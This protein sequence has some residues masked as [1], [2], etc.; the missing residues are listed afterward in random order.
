MTPVTIYAGLAGDRN[1]RGMRGARLLGDA[2]AVAAG[3]DARVVGAAAAPV[4]G[5]WAAQLAAARHG[6]GLLKS[7]VG[8]VLDA[9]GRPVS[10][11]GRCAASIATLPQV[12]RTHPDAAV[13]W[14]DAHGD[15]NVPRG[16]D[17]YLGGMVLTGAAGLWDTGLGAGLALGQTILVGSR[18][19]DP[20]ERERIARGDIGHVPAGPDLAARLR[21]AVRGRPVYVHL[22][23]DVLDAGLLATEYQV[24][25]GLSFADL[26]AACAALAAC[27]LIGLEITEYEGE[28]PDGRPSG[29]G[30]LL[31]AIAPLLAAAA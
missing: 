25:D 12:A 19:L 14:F 17:S 29:T 30:E 24:P 11:M 26:R 16:P 9:G 21:A 22:D 27:P 18:D 2:L 20:P 5:G 8:E 10:V 28:W 31:D 7:A 23:C 13:V 4:A 1:P 3:K 15:C 6:L